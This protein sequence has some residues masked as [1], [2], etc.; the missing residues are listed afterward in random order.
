MSTP[1][2]NFLSSQHWVHFTDAQQREVYVLSGTCI[3]NPVETGP[4]DGSRWHGGKPI[5]PFRCRTFQ[6]AR[7]W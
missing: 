4:Q 5:S 2:G 1:A 7:A 6:R 3:L